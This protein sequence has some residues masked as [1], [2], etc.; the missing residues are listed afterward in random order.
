M[1]SRYFGFGE[2]PFGVTPDPRFLYLSRVHREALASLQCAFHSN[3]GFTALIAPPGMGKTTLLF[4]FLRRVQDSARTAFLFN[5]HM[6]ATELL[7]ALL[8]EIGV[9]PADNI[10]QI[11][12]QLNNELLLTARDGRR[13]VVVVDEAQN[14]TETT[15]E[16][17]RLLTNFE[18]PRQKLMHL[19]LSGQ[20][21][22]ADKLFSPTLVQLRQR[23]STFCKLE[24]FSAEDTTSYIEHRLKIAGYTGS[25]LFSSDSL[26]RIAEAS[27]GIPRVVNTLCFNSLSLCHALGR[28]QVD[29]A[30]VNEAIQDLHPLCSQNEGANQPKPGNGNHAVHPLPR[31]HMRLTGMRVPAIASLLL[32]GCVAAFW[33]HGVHRPIPSE[34]ALPQAVQQPLVL[35]PPTVEPSR[36]N[37]NEKFAP[38]GLVEIIVGPEQ[39]LSAISV[40]RFGG[41]NDD[42]LRTIQHLNPDITDPNLIHTGQKILLPRQAITRVQNERLPKPEPEEQP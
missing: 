38:A 33:A 26:A 32:I 9:R 21:Q 8:R 37:A 34:P 15:L 22:L 3:R 24:P 30:M 10:G 11:L 23:I 7:K 12:E 4:E 6:D 14:L 27:E 19:V 28:K 35:P 25:P 40:N 20:P 39:T 16:T 1:Q 29:A 41:F 31:N 42:L 13:F 17:L 2:C 5:S 18:T 36:A